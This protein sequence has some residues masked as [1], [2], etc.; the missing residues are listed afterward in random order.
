[1]IKLGV[2]SSVQLTEACVVHGFNAVKGERGYWQ[3]GNK[4]NIMPNQVI[5]RILFDKAISYLTMTL[6]ERVGPQSAGNSPRIAGLSDGL[7]DLMA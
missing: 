2:N 3:T 4:G 1:M 5:N 7:M 6:A